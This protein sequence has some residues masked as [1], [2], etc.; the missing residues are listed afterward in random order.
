MSDFLAY[1]GK[2]DRGLNETVLNALEYI[3]WEKIVFPDSVVFVKPNF[4]YPYYKEGI[5]TS[6]EVLK[7]LLTLLKT[8]AKKVVVGESDGGNNSFQAETAFKNHGM[9]DIC[10]S[11]GVELVNLSRLPS[12]VVEETVSGKRVKVPMPDLLLDGV[13]CLISVP[14]LKVHVMTTVTLGLKNLWG[15]YP[16]TMRGL[17]HQNLSHK[18]ALLAKHL[19]PKITLID[20]V[21]GLDK[22]GPM[23]GEPVRLDLLL[24]AN[25]PVVADAL[26]ASIMGFNPGRINHIAVSAKV[27]GVTTDLTGVNI[28]QGWTPY[29]RSFTIRRTLIDRLSVPLFNS[30]QLSK[31]MLA[32]PF[33]RFAYAVVHLVR[34]K[35]EK[36]TAADIKNNS[37][38]H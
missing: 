31:L 5:T 12:R 4:T 32:S 22:H 38:F 19:K 37:Y 21:Y 14:V 16:D 26:G 36:M 3:E 34:S 7:S 15:C 24:A 30:Y 11:L 28:N 17:Y 18:L 25:S 2:T 9:Y 23:H 29:R 1:I 6:P 8:R 13:D 10:E 35:E 20:G 27:L 33:T